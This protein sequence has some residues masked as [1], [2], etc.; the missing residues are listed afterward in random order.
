MLSKPL[1]KKSFNAGEVSPTLW[2]RTDVERVNVGCRTLKNFF[3][4]PHGAAVRRP[5][6]V[7]WVVI[8]LNSD[9]DD[10]ATTEETGETTESTETSEE[11]T[12]EE[13]TETTGE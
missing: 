7:R 8:E 12:T 1:V 5:G 2:R 3:V 9:A 6:F 13:T 11:T 10:D 4:H